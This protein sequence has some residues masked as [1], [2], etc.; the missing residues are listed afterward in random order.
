M[1]IDLH[2]IDKSRIYFMVTMRPYEAMEAHRFDKMSDDMINQLYARFGTATE[3]IMEIPFEFHISS[4][5]RYKFIRCKLKNF[6]G[7][8]VRKVSNENLLN[9]FN[10]V[11]GYQIIQFNMV[12]TLVSF[13]NPFVLQ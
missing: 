2:I 8:E 5:H 11:E 10:T 3:S 7:E 4:G 6:P 13:S 12:T 1:L 9:S